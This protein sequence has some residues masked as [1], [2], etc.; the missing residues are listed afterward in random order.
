MKIW[1]KIYDR[2]LMF[3][4]IYSVYQKRKIKNLSFF[5]NV[6]LV[7][8][9]ELNVFFLDVITSILRIY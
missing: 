9:F 1:F 7:M 3:Y 6:H 5:S 8:H 2:K 4:Y